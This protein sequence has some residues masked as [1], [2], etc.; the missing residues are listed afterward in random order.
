MSTITQY[1]RSGS[2]C[3]YNWLHSAVA[4]Q[5]S[6]HLTV[7]APSQGQGRLIKI[8]QSLDLGLMT[9]IYIIYWQGTTLTEIVSVHTVGNFCCKLCKRTN[10]W[11]GVRLRAD[12]SHQSREMGL[13]VVI[14]V[15]FVFQPCWLRIL[16]VRPC[17]PRY[18]L[19]R[20]GRMLLS[21]NIVEAQAVQI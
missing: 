18:W 16:L 1:W 12:I 5:P 13:V 10:I 15:V 6:T 4:D 11:C 9:F 14:F 19:L 7:L 17:H 20:V 8:N 2:N 21:V 3:C